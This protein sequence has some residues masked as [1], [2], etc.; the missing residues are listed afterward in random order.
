M[1]CYGRGELEVSGGAGVMGSPRSKSLGGMEDELKDN[2]GREGLWYFRG[3]QR[4]EDEESQN[5]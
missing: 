3:Q 5:S 1:Q 4:L 2:S